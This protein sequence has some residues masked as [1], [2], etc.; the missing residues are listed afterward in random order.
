[1]IRRLSPLVAR[2]LALALVGSFVAVAPAEIAAKQVDVRCSNSATDARK[3]NAAIAD[4]Q[5]GDEIVIDGPCLINRVIKLVGNRSYRG[6]SRTG[7]VLAQADGANLKALLASDSYLDNAKTTGN[8]VAVR[9]L[10]LDGNKANNTARTAGMVLRSWQ[11]VVEDVQIL[12]TG[13]DGIRLTNPSAD[14]TELTNTQ[15]N[16]QIV[17]NFVEHAGR[18][19]IAVDDPGNAVTDWNLT[20]NWIGFSGV[21]GIHLENAAGWVVERNHVYGV[22]ET[23]IFAHRLYGTSISDNYV[24]G[25][26]ESG[27]AGNWYGINATVQGKAASTI[28][29]NRVFN[30]AGEATEGSTYRYIALSSVNYDSGLCSVT[31]NV[32]RGANT[33]AGTGLYY[34]GGENLLTVVSSGNA[35]VDVQTPIF[36]GATVTVD[37]GE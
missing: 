36:V 1:M 27:T 14:G 16:G 30:F 26:G 2:A 3:I 10:T 31:G 8:P 32:V 20:E 9:H 33:P 19:G 5:V 13:G 12:Q 11:T 21:D 28:A 22:P 4:S 25:F 17:G 7:T 34:D 29:N 6:Q 18:H 15:V 23:A 35:I 24:E 37:A